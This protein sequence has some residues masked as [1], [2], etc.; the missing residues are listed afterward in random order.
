MAYHFKTNMKNKVMAR[1]YD[2]FYKNLEMNV[3][4]FEVTDFFQL[5]LFSL[6][7]KILRPL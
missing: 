5:I 6:L 7:F 4:Q 3:L 1:E 2:A